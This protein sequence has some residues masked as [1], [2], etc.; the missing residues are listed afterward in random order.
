M[1]RR[2]TL[3]ELR[4]DDRGAVLVVV[5]VALA[6]FL[7]L[8]AMSFDVGRVAAT[9][10]ELQSYVD[11][12]ALA[13]AAEL[14]G[15]ADAIVRAR[16]AA[17][18]LIDDSQTFA[19]GTQALGSTA[20]YTLTFL[21]TLPASDNA[22]ATAVTTN[23]EDAAFVRVDATPRDVYMGFARA[24]VA[25]T[26]ANDTAP[27]GT[28]TATATAGFTQLACDVVPMM[29]CL[30]S[31]DYRA[32]DHVGEMVKLRAGGNGAAWGPGDF[33]FLDPS[34]IF[35]DPA[36]P[37]AGLT[38]VNLDACLLGAVDSLTQCFSLRGVDIEPGQKVGI[39]D[40]IFNVRFDMY[41]T[42]M[43]AERTD[44]DYAPAPNV[45]KGVELRATGGRTC[46]P[47][48]PAAI[49][50]LQPP[51]ATSGWMGL[52]HDPVLDTAGNTVRFS[53]T[54]GFEPGSPQR[55]AYVAANYGG[56]DPHPAAR[57]RYEYYLAEIAAHGGAAAL[58]RILA[59]PRL[60]TGRPQ[61]S[62]APAAD[63]DRRIITVAGI[64]CVAHEIR[65]AATNVPVREYFR[66]FLTEPVRGGSDFSIFGEIVGSAEA[67]GG[68]SGESAPIHDL[69]QL[70]R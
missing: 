20:D 16:A 70:Y 8:V 64:D 46:A 39:E 65:G 22:A 63:A 41:N 66:I 23:P 42:I 17:D 14:D 7:G 32:D 55:Q 25:L 24:M 21:S 48:N 49:S 18:A 3:A 51:T 52:P 15:N 43:N 59:D 9:Q 13:A 69:V 19:T 26:P 1:P 31:A 11:A 4:Q 57:T 5:G 35:V 45:L 58:D 40:S 68:S 54:R 36:G 53:G 10:S 37:C 61:C 47:N 38:G 33:G 27:S 34:R 6:V 12:V 28:V 2:A 56:T 50:P 30:P 67:G 62:A 44:P 60:E 29:F